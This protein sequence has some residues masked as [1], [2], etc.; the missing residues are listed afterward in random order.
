M[1]F[2]VR[3][4]LVGCG[5]YRCNCEVDDNQTS[6]VGGVSGVVMGAVRQG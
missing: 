2:G 1:S 5:L 6:E 4:D 3:F